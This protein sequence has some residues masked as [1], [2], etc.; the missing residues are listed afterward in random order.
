MSNSFEMLVEFLQRFGDE[1][2]GRALVEP[3]EP[4]QR[5]LEALA[6]GEV[7]ETDRR[8]LMRQLS[9]HPEWVARLAAELQALRTRGGTKD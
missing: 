3:P 8:E 9:T 2:E 7:S 1:V 5:Q 6:R 4:V